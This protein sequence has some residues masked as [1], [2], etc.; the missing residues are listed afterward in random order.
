MGKRFCDYGL[1]FVVRS[2]GICVGSILLET[3]AKASVGGSLLPDICVRLRVRVCPEHFMGPD[4]H[5]DIRKFG[6]SGTKN[7]H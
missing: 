3:L 4:I 5:P 6:V 2:C 7:A 1:N